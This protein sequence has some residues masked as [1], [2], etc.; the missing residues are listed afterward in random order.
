[1]RTKRNLIEFNTPPDFKSGERQKKFYKLTSNGLIA[2]ISENP[3]PY[4]FWIALMWYCSLNTEVVNK[5]QLN[6][7]Y[8][9]SIQKFVGNSFPSPQF[10]F[11]RFF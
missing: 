8:S 10:F 11:N 2:F 5:N 6:M 3:T 7:Y 1:M 4:E 9:L